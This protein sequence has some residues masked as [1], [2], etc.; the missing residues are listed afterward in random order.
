MVKEYVRKQIEGQV[1]GISMPARAP[2]KLDF[3]N[4]PGDPGLFGPGAACWE[5]HG[6]F[7]SMLIGGMSALLL[8]MLD[9]LALAGVLD[10]SNFRTDMLGR[11]RRTAQFIAGTTF[12][13]T[14]DANRL[15]AR[16]QAIHAEVSGVTQDGRSYSATDPELL[17]WV[18]VAEVHS[19]LQS[20]LRYKNPHLSPARQDQYFDEYALIAEQLGA[21]QVPRSRAAVERY[22]EARRGALSCDARTLEVFDL[23]M[24]A[25]SP[26]TSSRWFTWL[27][28]RAA[29]DLLPAWG[30]ELFGRKPLP[31]P[32]RSVLHTTTRL[33]VKP[34][35]WAV[36]N[37]ASALAHRR[38]QA[39]TLRSPSPTHR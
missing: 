16:V 18:H 24:R 11:L 8:Q 5:V 37:S 27:V 9:P 21:I 32:A 12:G 15:I 3:S 2:L 31:A 36:R 10:H 13:S 33:S 28:K 39:S 4:P 14:G 34:V 38:V 23:V 1:L 19:F 35:R 22:L 17:T 29:V 25:P 30:L 20:H 6:D 26:G 7:S